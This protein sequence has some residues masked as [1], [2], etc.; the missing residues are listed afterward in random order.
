MQHYTPTGRNGHGV[1]HLILSRKF[2]VLTTG[3]GITGCCG[4]CR[5]NHT[6]YKTNKKDENRL[7]CTKIDLVT[8]A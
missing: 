3:I 5:A 8:S 1:L 7:K 2:E 6:K 4:N